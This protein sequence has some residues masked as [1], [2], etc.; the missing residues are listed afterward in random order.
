M[1]RWTVKSGLSSLRVD[2]R[3]W[4]RVKEATT[5]VLMTIRLSERLTVRT[6]TIIISMKR[7]TRK[8]F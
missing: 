7:I 3:I 6:V 1:N 4:E 5:V 2:L 8:L